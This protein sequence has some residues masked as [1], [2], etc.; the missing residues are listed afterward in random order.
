[1]RFNVSEIL[2][3]RGRERGSLHGLRWGGRFFRRRRNASAL[4]T[5]SPR[6]S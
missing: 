6:S 4:E 3:C 1:M 2:R 5:P